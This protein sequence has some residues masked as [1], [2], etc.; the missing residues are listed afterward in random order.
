MENKTKGN[1]ALWLKIS[2]HEMKP[3][4]AS[5]LNY[6]S[7]YKYLRYIIIAVLVIITG[8][9]FFVAGKRFEIGQLQTI[10]STLAAVMGVVLL[11]LIV[12]GIKLFKTLKS[13][14]K[15]V[16]KSAKKNHLEAKAFRKEF[17]NYVKATFGGPG[18]R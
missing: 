16:N 2:G 18:L 9:N 8:Y 3:L 17:H 14:K 13:L 6:A 10:Q 7:K 5:Y 15:D 11:A 12:L 1:F 4:V